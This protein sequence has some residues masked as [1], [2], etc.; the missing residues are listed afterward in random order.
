VPERRPLVVYALP[1]RGMI[2]DL[3]GPARAIVVVRDLDERPLPP[4]FHLTSVFGL[5]AAESKLAARL[6]AGEALDAVADELGIARETARNQ[7]K[8]IFLKTGVH[9]QAELAALLSR[10]LDRRKL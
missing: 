9:R 3:F 10:F 8:A 7:L 6:G 4:T 1:L 5:T 2:R